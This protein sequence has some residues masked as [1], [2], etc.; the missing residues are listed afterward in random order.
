MPIETLEDILEELADRQ[1]VYGAHPENR[2]LML[3]EKCGCR[4]CFL[5][6]IR[7]RIVRAV[8]IEKL[9]NINPAGRVR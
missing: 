2:E 7:D 5:A 4:I 9:L 3:G 1:G 6:G 8:E